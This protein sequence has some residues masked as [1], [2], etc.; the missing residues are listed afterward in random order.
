MSEW[1]KGIKGVAD[2]PRVEI[3]EPV[4]W[5]PSCFTLGDF[6]GATQKVNGRVTYINSEHRWYLAEAPCNGR[7]IR[8][9]FKF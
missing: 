7:V 2:A 4:S 9:G 8:E 5:V 1:G 6:P 3:G